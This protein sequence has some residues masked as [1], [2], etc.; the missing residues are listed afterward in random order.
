MRILVKIIDEERLKIKRKKEWE[1]SHRSMACKAIGQLRRFQ[2]PLG[3]V[4]GKPSEDYGPSSQT[5]SHYR[6][7]MT[8][9]LISRMKYGL[10]RV[11]KIT[12]PDLFTLQGNATISNGGVLRV[13]TSFSGE[14]LMMG[15]WRG[16]LT[17]FRSFMPFQASPMNL[18]SLFGD[19]ITKECSQ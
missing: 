16:S 12:F 19:C 3:V 18:T 11:P 17:C 14:H 13:G 1:S 10:G 8:G 6:W 7:G 5:T 9:K 15:R 4:C 2:E